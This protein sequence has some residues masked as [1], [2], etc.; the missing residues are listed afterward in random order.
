MGMMEAFEDFDFAIEIVLELLVE[1]REVHRL[2]SYKSSG[3][4]KM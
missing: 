4:L 3:T 1:L 2:D